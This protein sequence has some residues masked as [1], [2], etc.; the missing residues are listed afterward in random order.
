ME[1]AD[2]ER[3][4]RG[5]AASEAGRTAKAATRGS[6]LW[7]SDE[8]RGAGPDVPGLDGAVR[9]RPETTVALPVCAEVVSPRG[10]ASAGAP[11]DLT[12]KRQ[13]SMRVRTKPLAWS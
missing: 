2:R 11:E 6:P 9:G 5:R 4:E 1:L 10:R 7:A 12:Q 3:L 13:V 8:R